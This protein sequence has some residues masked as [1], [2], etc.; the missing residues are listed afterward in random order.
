MQEAVEV[1]VP[2]LEEG[3]PTIRPTQAVSLG[4]DLYR[5]LP[6]KDYDPENE[7]WEFLPGSVVRCDKIRARISGEMILRAYEVR[8][9]DGS[10]RLSEDL[11]KNES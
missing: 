8:L 7:V 1:Y 2:L 11:R 3:T 10:F 9:P 5:I 4:G 6:T